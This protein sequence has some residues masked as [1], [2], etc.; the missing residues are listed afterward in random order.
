M[1]R[2][3]EPRWLNGEE[4]DVWLTLVAVIMKLPAALDA[5][6]QQDAGISHFEYMVLAG[7]SEAPARTR[8]MSD[9]AGFTE[10]GL[11]RLSQVVSR[12]EK[13]G[14]VHRS[15]DPSDGRITLAT[16]TDEGW[17]KITRTAPGHVEAV[18]ALVFDPLTKA[19]SRQ[20]GSIGKRIMAAVDPEDRCLGES[21][22]A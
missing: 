17:A 2:A 21:A 6:L 18:R 19:Q 12:L 11:P 5:Q 1:E 7:L 10:S 14:W 8:R 16:L 4:R 22:P 13:R 9:L 15:T 20:L 3:E